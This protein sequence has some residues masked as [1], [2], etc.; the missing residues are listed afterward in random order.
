MKKQVKVDEA[1]EARI[2][3]AYAEEIKKARA[4]EESKNGK[5]PAPKKKPAK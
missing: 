1:A 5:K 2:N 3:Q 4:K